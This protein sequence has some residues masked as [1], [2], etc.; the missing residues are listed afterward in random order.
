MPAS[1]TRLPLQSVSFSQPAQAANAGNCSNIATN[2][3]TP[4]CRPMA[5]SGRGRAAPKVSR[6]FLIYRFPQNSSVQL[7]VIG[8]AQF[9]LFSAGIAADIA[10]HST[11]GNAGDGRSIQK[12]SLHRAMCVA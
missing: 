4:W 9:V 2:T 12:F 5:N 7:R 6:D 3:P 1:Q 10:T 8:G 11:F